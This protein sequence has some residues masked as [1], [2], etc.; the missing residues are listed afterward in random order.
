[1][2]AN[3]QPRRH[4]CNSTPYSPKT[5]WLVGF[6]PAFRAFLSLSLMMAA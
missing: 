1:V 5:H 2:K 6:N 3:S 4:S